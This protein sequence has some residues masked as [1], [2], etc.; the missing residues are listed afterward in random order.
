MDLRELLELL[1]DAE[2]ELLM[3]QRTVPVG[4]DKAISLLHK[5]IHGKD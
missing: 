2:D 1:E 3:A 5:E 4:L